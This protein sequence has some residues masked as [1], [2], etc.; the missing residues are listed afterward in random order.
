MQLP[1]RVRATHTS[2]FS[3]LA[4]ALALILGLSLITA[5]AHAYYSTIDTGDLVA[6]GH[7]QAGL[8]VQ[9]VM[10][11]HPGAN[12]VG[13]VDT[14]ID[15]SSSIRGILG[16]GKVDF[17]LGG[18]YKLI[19]F[20]DTA[21]QPAMGFEA[22]ALIARVDGGE[23]QVSLRFHPLISKRLESEIGNITPYGSIPFGLTFG[24]NGV[25]I[26][27]QF[28]VGVELRP[29]NL[30]N[31]S[32]FAELGLQ[33]THSFSYVSIAAAYRFDDGTSAPGHQVR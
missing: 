27:S 29:L 8:E 26:P 33:M 23:T 20:P 24:N 2:L 32:L 14:G 6:P 4:F 5:P 12:V 11:N 7:Y 17:Q 18:M 28:V 19:P 25:F 1:R 16:F 22:G 3:P 30:P 10:N 13:R 9:G 21:S 31:L 15:D